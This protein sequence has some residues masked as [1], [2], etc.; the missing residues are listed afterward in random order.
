MYNYLSGIYKKNR[1]ANNT[2]KRKL[3]NWRPQK[4]R[5]L[6]VFEKLAEDSKRGSFIDQLYVSECRKLRQIQLHSG[7][8]PSGTYIDTSDINNSSIKLDT[9]SGAAIVL[10]QSNSGSVIVILYAFKSHQR[11][12]DC[13]QFI[14]SVFNS[15]D[16]LTHCVIKKI[17][18]D[19]FAL[20]RY[21]SSFYTEGFYDYLRIR[22]LIFKGKYYIQN[23][24]LRNSFIDHWFICAL[25]VVGSICSITSVLF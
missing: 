11:K 12:P 25:G 5:V 18:K 9:E 10:S 13:E 21:S 23:G 20:S 7:R 14:W 22:Y 2:R 3:L 16:E 24:S 1:Q 17:V 8:H 19:F 4:Q 6:D 15:P